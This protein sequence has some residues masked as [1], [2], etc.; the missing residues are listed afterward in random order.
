MTLTVH[1]LLHVA[2]TI[3]RIGPV[4]AWWSF[5]IERQCGRLQRHIISRRHPF[6]NLDNYITLAAQF[7]TAK[8]IYNVTDEDLSLERPVQKKKG[9]E[10][11]DEC[12]CCLYTT[13]GMFLTLLDCRR[14]DHPPWQ[15]S[16]G[17]REEWRLFGCYKI[18]LIYSVWPEAQKNSRPILG[19]PPHYVRGI[20][21]GHNR[22]RRSDSRC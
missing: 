2:D 7:K 9:F 19:T 8:L 4:W 18:L 15:G 17:T 14:R 13:C 5:P 21:A 6:A 20:Q 1:G 16:P 11:H 10:L 22:Q 12:T 3:E